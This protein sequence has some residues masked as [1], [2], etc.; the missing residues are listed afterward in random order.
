MFVRLASLAF[1]PWLDTSKVR[2]CRFPPDPE[3]VLLVFVADCILLG[4]VGSQGADAA[5]NLGGISV[6]LVWLARLGT[7][8]YYAFF[9]VIL[10]VVGLIETPK[11]LPDSIAK[12]VLGKGAAPAPAE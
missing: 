1:A 12:S 11:K 3:A 7:L 6:P 9:W 4:Y 2:S 5:W 8:Y 10:P